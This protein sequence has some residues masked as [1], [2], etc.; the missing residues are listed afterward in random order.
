MLLNESGERI[1]EVYTWWPTTG[2]EELRADFHR[3]AC[4]MIASVDL[5]VILT[6]AGGGRPAAPQGRRCEQLKV[7][8]PWV[9]DQGQG[10]G[11]C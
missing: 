5:D 11:G 1:G 4:V 10:I 9:A 6:H 8:F 2:P 7:M 3:D